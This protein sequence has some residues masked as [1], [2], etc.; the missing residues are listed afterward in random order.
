MFTVGNIYY[1][2]RETDVNKKEIHARSIKE[3]VTADGIICPDIAI[4]ELCV[5]KDTD[6]SG[7]YKVLDIKK[8][9]PVYDGI[10]SIHRYDVEL[11]VTKVADYN[12][13]NKLDMT[14]WLTRLDKYGFFTKSVKYH[15]NDSTETEGFAIDVKRGIIF[16][17]KTYKG[18]LRCLDTYFF[19]PTKEVL[20]LMAF[21][22]LPFAGNFAPKPTKFPGSMSKWFK[23]SSSR[24]DIFSILA[25][26]NNT[27]DNCLDDDKM[28][29]DMPLVN[30]EKYEHPFVGFGGG[31]FKY[32]YS[33]EEYKS[34][35]RKCRKTFDS[36]PVNIQEFILK[37]TNVETKYFCDEPWKRYDN[38]LIEKELYAKHLYHPYF[39]MNKG[40]EEK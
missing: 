20:R 13:Y 12:W 35:F 25:D 28:Y 3:Y 11:A 19:K 9:Q 22:I 38:E 21:D 31:L 27:F 37:Y 34:Y 5:I 10:G 26:Y 36:L 8:H 14:W 39:K 30:S 2:E 6:E 15:D 32:P 4:Q 23:V 29:F 1:F 18:V 40:G 33:Q 7:W 17:L 24:P 16:N